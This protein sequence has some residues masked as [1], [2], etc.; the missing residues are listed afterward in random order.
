MSRALRPESSCWVRV[1]RVRVVR[2]RVRV[3][4]VRVRVHIMMNVSNFLVTLVATLVMQRRWRL[5]TLLFLFGYPSYSPN[6]NPPVCSY[7][8]NGAAGIGRRHGRAVHQLPLL[9]GMRG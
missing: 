1:V 8:S 4:R 5:S 9:R 7:H 3:V 2:V 6:P